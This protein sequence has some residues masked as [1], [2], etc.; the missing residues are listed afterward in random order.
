MEKQYQKTE[1]KRIK[2]NFIKII[3]FISLLFVFS[4]WDFIEKFIRSLF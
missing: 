4:Q 3:I 2:R 1:K